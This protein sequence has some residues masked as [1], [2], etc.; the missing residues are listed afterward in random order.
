MGQPFSGSPLHTDPFSRMGG[1]G[2]VDI[3]SEKLNQKFKL[4]TEPL[5]RASSGLLVT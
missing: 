2:G 3:V 1:G 5:M 4:V